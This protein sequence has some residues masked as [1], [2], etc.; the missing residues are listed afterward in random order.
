MIDKEKKSAILMLQDGTYF[1]GIGFGATIKV[2]G[3]ITFSAIPG[4]GY[5]EILTDSTLKD[6]IVLLSLI[7]I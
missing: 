5:I 1:E 6:K 4:S 7:H 2:S 3:E